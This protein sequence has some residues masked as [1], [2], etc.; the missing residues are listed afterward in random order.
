[1]RK[2]FSGFS[3]GFTN[4]LNQGTLSEPPGNVLEHSR[5]LFASVALG[6]VKVR[7]ACGRFTEA[8][9]WACG[10]R[11]ACEG[12]GLWQPISSDTSPEGTGLETADSRPCARGA[13]WV[14]RGHSSDSGDVCCDHSPGDIND[15]SE[16]AVTPALGRAPRSFSDASALAVGVGRC[17]IHSLPDLLA[18]QSA[19]FCGHKNASFMSPERIR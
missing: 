8:A 13:D 19:V 9:G 10:W 4:F 6:L 18:F 16:K 12:R 1:M 15:G 2:P 3:Q 7:R 5:D 11:G 14:V 17:F